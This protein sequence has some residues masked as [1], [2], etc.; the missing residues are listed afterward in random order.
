[1]QQRTMSKRIRFAFISE[2]KR[3]DALQEL[4]GSSNFRHLTTSILNSTRGSEPCYYLFVQTT[5]SL[6]YDI[7]SKNSIEAI[8]NKHGGYRA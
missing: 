3:D 8:M 4:S 7:V 5:G 2:V 6:I 1:M